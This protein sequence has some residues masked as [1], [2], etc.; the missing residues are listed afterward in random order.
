MIYVLYYFIVIMICQV[1]VCFLEKIFF[2]PK[3]TG[4]YS[5]YTKVWEREESN[6]ERY[7]RILP[8]PRKQKD[9]NEQKLVFLGWFISPAVV[10]MLSFSAIVK[11]V[12]NALPE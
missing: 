7:I 4:Y 3:Q 9:F 11:V 8:I 12:T 5:G 2:P 10:L 6:N 1:I